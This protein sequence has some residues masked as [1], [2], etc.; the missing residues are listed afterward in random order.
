[1]PRC[2]AVFEGGGVKGIGLVGAVA[3]TEE[4]NYEFCNIAGTS[5]G[6]IVAALVAAG[7]RASELHD[8]M[9]SLDYAKFK[10]QGLL[11]RIPVFGKVLSLGLEKG[12]YEGT[13]L[14][15]WLREQLGA[16]GKHTFKD[17]I[18]EESKDS[19]KY[20][21]K[22]QVIAADISRG[23]LLV[24]PR[25]IQDY[26]IDPDDLDI[27]H[28]VRMSMSIPFFFEPV[29]LQLRD[30]EQDCYIVD[31]GVLSNFPIY[32]FDDG[33]PDPPW[34]TFGY[35]LA[36]TSDAVGRSVSHQVFGPLSLLA[37]L[38]LTMMEAHDRIYI[39]NGAFARTIMIPTLGV[40]TTDF[41]LS[42]QRAE[43]LY[44]SGL[45]AG[46]EFFHTWDF[47]Q[48]KAVFRQAAE[49]NRREMLLTAAASVRQE[50]TKS[51]A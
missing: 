37:S 21:Y 49:K 17:L 27:A 34:P 19:P 6:A 13:L 50:S 11:D 28:A 32:L 18:I 5:A 26:G 23:K 16:K 43:A 48:Y 40:E 1:M 12:I 39:A 31:G 10:D 20:R 15:H 24:L 51:S 8:I 7:Y 38:F 44:Q 36:E 47:E 29:Q 45:A 30:P 2:D 33:T 3:A 25:D 9:Q 14:E 22:L 35:M 46:R 42:P 4:L 41:D